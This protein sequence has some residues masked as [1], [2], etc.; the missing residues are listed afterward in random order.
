M[1]IHEIALFYKQ[2]GDCHGT[3]HVYENCYR[4]CLQASVDKC[5]GISYSLML[6]G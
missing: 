1:Q 3:P 4:L 5:G 6:F 2:G